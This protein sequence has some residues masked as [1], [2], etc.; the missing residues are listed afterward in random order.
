MANFPDAILLQP[1][2][3]SARQGSSTLE[4]EQRI[5]RQSIEKASQNLESVFLAEMLK[6]G[7]LGKV[8]SEFGGERSEFSSILT[9]EYAR[10]MA[11]AGGIGLAA[12]LTEA[13]L[14]LEQKD[15]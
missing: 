3:R 10:S 6:A 13:M 15:A 5:K 1:T 14:R 11:E 7:G 4:E 12:Q 9:N 8:G 2:W